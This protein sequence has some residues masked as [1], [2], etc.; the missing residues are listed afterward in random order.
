[1]AVA[2]PTLARKGPWIMTSEPNVNERIDLPGYEGRWCALQVR[3]QHEFV[4]SRLLQEKGYNVFVPSIAIKKR[5]S[6]RWKEIETPLFSGYVFCELRYDTAG[7][8]IS[9]PSVIRIIG[10]SKAPAFIPDAEIRAIQAAVSSGYRVQASPYLEIG[11]TVRIMSG[12]LAGV[13]G[14]L[15]RHGNQRQ[16][17]LSVQLVQRSITVEI[18]QCS[19]M[20]L[21]NNHSIYAMRT[22]G[23]ASPTLMS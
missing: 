23:T 22:T 2:R 10:T 4:S 14:R 11:A 20:A 1:M 18:D 21:D 16:L 13:E 5:W 9:T 3:Y 6:D 12:P 17:I 15:T 8:I 7:A 19:V